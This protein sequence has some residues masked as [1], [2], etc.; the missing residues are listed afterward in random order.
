M[1]T[2]FGVNPDKISIKALKEKFN[3][4][5]GRFNGGI[6][7]AFK[8]LDQNRATTINQSI[9]NKTLYTSFNSRNFKPD[10]TLQTYTSELKNYLNKHPNKTVRII[11]HTDNIGD[12]N[13]N[14]ILAYDRATNVL[15]YFVQ[16]GISKNKLKCFSKGETKPVATNATQKGRALNRS[17]EIKVN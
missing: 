6:N 15:N 3:Y 13:N 2:K 12:E 8:D 7:M 17:I 14:K 10:N 5:N 9:T 1:L 4:S 11:G 16:N